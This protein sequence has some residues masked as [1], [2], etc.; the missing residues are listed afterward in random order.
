MQVQR[1]GG[2]EVR[3][4]ASSVQTWKYRTHE[5]W[6]FGAV[7]QACGRGGMVRWRRAASVPTWKRGDKDVLRHRGALQACRCRG[8]EI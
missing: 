5:L 8:M 7:L 4:H 3:S 1:H 6:S 2:M